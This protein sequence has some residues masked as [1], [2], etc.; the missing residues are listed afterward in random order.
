MRDEPG[1]LNLARRARSITPSTIVFIAVLAAVVT[2]LKGPR[3][4]GDEA[5]QVIAAF[6]LT[7][8]VMMTVV[9]WSSRRHWSER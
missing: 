2:M 4:V 6:I 8:G 3:G 1:G 9:L 5:A 7:A